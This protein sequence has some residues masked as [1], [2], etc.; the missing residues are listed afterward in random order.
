MGV[1][2]FDV[3]D[4]LQRMYFYAAIFTIFHYGILQAAFTAHLQPYENFLAS[5]Y[6]R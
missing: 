3:I 2:D 4:D 6:K 1:S 5:C